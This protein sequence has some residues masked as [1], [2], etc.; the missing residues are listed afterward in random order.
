MRVKRLR[1]AQRRKAVGLSQESLAEVLGVDPSTVRRWERADNDPQPWHRPNLARALRVT[2]DELVLLLTDLDERPARGYDLATQGACG[3]DEQ[4]DRRSLL[5]LAAL[6]VVAGAG[7]VVELLTPTGLPMLAPGVGVTTA[8]AESLA[9]QCKALYQACKYQKALQLAPGLITGLGQ[10][11]TSASGEEDRRVQR[12]LADTYHVIASIVLKLGDRVLAVLAAQRSL[13]AARATGEPV[14][15]ACSARA[16]THALMNAGHADRAI[17]VARALGDSLRRSPAGNTPDGLSAFGALMLRAAIAAARADQ[18]QTAA[19][20]LNE[21]EIAATLLGRDANDRWTGFGP[22]NVQLH[23]VHIAL[24]FDD[25]GVALAKAD[26]VDLSRVKLAERKAT[27]L[28]NVAQARLMRGR[29]AEALTALEQAYG[30]APEEVAGRPM[31]RRICNQ[32][33]ASSRGPVRDRVYRFALRAGLFH[34]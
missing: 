20:L 27:F 32:L 21:A 15:V 19:E 18:R 17:S 34:G 29:P 23:K 6:P 33:I 2:L 1:L 11:A 25:A 28:C 13:E 5:P 3:Q 26:R 22:T 31:G 14:I 30:V 12:V 8:Q 7:A 9:K 16:M 4:V 10:L 24:T